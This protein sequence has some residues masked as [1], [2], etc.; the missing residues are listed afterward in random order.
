VIDNAAR[1][2]VFNINADIEFK[3]IRHNSFP[4]V[5]HADFLLL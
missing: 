1:V 3:I 5:L 4:L 2:C